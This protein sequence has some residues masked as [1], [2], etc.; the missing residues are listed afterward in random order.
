MIRIFCS[1]QPSHQLITQILCLSIP[2][3]F[4]LHEE[5]Y[6][7]DEWLETAGNGGLLVINFWVLMN[8]SDSTCKIVGKLKLTA[9]L[10]V[11]GKRTATR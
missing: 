4:C 3:R 1:K 6:Q 10:R 5:T 8:G 11:R 7:K 9:D 2:V